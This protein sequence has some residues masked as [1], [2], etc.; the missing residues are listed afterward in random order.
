[1]KNSP[2]PSNHGER[3]ARLRSR[4]RR[5]RLRRPGLR[6]GLLV[7]L[8]VT[9]LVT[10]L[11]PVLVIDWSLHLGDVGVDLA[12]RLVQ[13]ALQVG[14]LPRLVVVAEVLQHELVVAAVGARGRRGA[15]RV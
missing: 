4:S 6:A 9:V 12:G 11:V 15:V 2:V 3:N 13:S 14:L 5:R 10:V 8:L 1:M 7:R